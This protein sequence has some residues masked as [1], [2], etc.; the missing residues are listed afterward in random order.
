[1]NLAFINYFDNL[2]DSLKFPILLHRTT[3]KW[4]LPI[5]LV[6]FDFEPELLITPKPLKDF[7]YQFQY[8]KEL[9]DLQEWH[10]TKN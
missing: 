4:I 3:Y 1:M 5:S 8:E 7:A 6:T 10:I 9:F 2:I